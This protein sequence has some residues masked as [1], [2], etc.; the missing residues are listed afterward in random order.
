MLNIK[1]FLLAI[2]LV[3]KDTTEIN[4]QGE[5]E[6]LNTDGKLRYC[7][8]S[9]VSPVVTESHSA[10]LTNKTID[11][12]G[13]GNSI[14]NLE[15]A[16]L[17]DGVLNT[18]L[19]D[20]LIENPASDT[21]IPSAL[22]VKTYVDAQVGGKDEAD[23]IIVDPAVAGATNVQSA[24]T[25]IN[26]AIN[27][28]IGD[29]T[30]AHDA[31]AISVVPTG[32]LA[33]DDVQEALQELQTDIDTRAT[34]TALTNHTGA[35]TGAHAASAI[36]V[37]PTVGGA[38]NVQT[39][40]TNHQAHVSA[41]TNVHGLAVGS[42]VVGTTDTQELTNKTLTGASIKTPVRSDVKQDTIANLTT[43]AASA[44]N[45]QI[46]FATDEKQMYQIVDNE[47]V[48]VG[49]ASTVTLIQGEL[50]SVND[51]V[52]ISTGT[53]NDSA[54]TAGYLYKVDATNDSRAD[55]LGF[56]KKI[57]PSSSSTFDE[58]F[59]SGNFTANG[60]TVVNGTQTNKFHVGTATTL[61]GSYSAYISNDSGVSNA[62]TTT[63][64]TSAVYFYKDLLVP[65]TG[66]LTFSYKSVG[67]FI[68]STPYDY[69]QIIIDPNLTVV[70]VAG[71]AI[72]TTPAGGIRQVL[73]STSLWTDV[74]INLSAYSGS[75]VRIIFGWRN[76]SAIGTQ[77]PLAIDNINL[78]SVGA[79]EV[80]TSGNFAGLSGLTAGKV[81]YAS[82]STPGAITATPPSTNGQWIIPSALAVSASEIVINPVASASSI[83]VVD[84]DDS[85]TIVNAQ[86]S[87]ANITGLLFDPIVT[88]S[89]SLDYVIYR[90]TDTASSAVAQTGQLRGVYNTQAAIWLMSDD[91]SGQN[92]AVTFSIQPS[93]QIQYT[94]SDITGANYIGSLKYN[95]RKTFGV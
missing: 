7:N 15:T 87:P 26:T 61:S 82:A 21:Q 35:T 6:V 83:Y 62:Y 38:S 66:I 20:A 94:S 91:F 39:A 18:D 22:A 10:T 64:G 53:D 28:H 3:P 16:D 45:G 69:G 85:F 86:L 72:T 14:S 11:A 43:Y 95:I 84:N 47:L 60:W 44:T 65:S 56:V 50:L 5:L 80:Q 40:L 13:T 19:I 75:T 8:G 74:T 32:N 33:A 23:E 88:R 1:K 41:S 70:P 68:G 59:E 4:S 73:S 27:D 77:P 42:S 25:N 58:T 34:S 9:S 90:Q 76:D 71:T 93:G 67:E 31:S 29:T 78:S 57:I 12:N 17:A 49:G 52:Y 37:D 54:R 89:F 55:A 24:L 51:Y 63:G 30:D 81:Y 92:A 46:V 48:T 79:A 2:G 36:S